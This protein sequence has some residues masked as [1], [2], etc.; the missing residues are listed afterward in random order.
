MILKQLF[1]CFMTSGGLL[2]DIEVLSIIDF[3]PGNILFRFCSNV[4]QK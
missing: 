4:S 2:F 1:G 3:D